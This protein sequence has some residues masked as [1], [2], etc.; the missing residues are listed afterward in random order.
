MNHSFNIDIAKM[1]DVNQA[2]IIENMSYWLKKN[3]ANNKHIYDGNVWTYNTVNALCEIFPYWTKNQIRRF[4]EKMEY[5][6]IIK[7]GNYNKANYDR[8]KWYAIV[9]KTIC[10]IYQIELANLPNGNGGFAKPIPD[11]NTDIIH[12]K[13]K[14]KKES[15]DFMSVQGLNYKYWIKWKEFK[16]EQFKN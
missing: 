3:I 10:Q 7:V 1:L 9:D 12:I 15:F 14:V 5:N 4:L 2:I 6:N 11:I 8:T 16:K 13:E